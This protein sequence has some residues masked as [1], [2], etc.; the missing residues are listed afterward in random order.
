MHVLKIRVLLPV[1]ALLAATLFFACGGGDNGDD[2]DTEQPT[3]TEQVDAGGETPQDADGDADG[4]AASSLRNL[5][6]QFAEQE[7]KVA[8]TFSTTSAGETMDG[9]FTLY[10]KPP[11]S[12]R[13]DISSPDGDATILLTGGSSYLCTAE[14]GGQCLQSPLGNIPVPFLSYFTDPNGLTDLVDTSLGGADVDVEESSREIAGQDATCFSVSG[15][16]E[17]EQGSGEYCFSDDGILL[18]VSA[19]SDQGDFQLEATSV[20]GSVSDAD[21]EPPYPVQEIPGLDDIQGLE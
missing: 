18:L 11:D 10:W 20:E 3:A 5:A 17:G 8:Y 15:T 14:G 2:G 19:S 16:I 9:S 7:A 12:W 13:M 21:L 4:D 6:G 1:A